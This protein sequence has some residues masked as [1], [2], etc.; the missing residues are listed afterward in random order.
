LRLRWF[1]A[2][3]GLLLFLRWRLCTVDSRDFV[4]DAQEAVHGND[5]PQ[6]RDARERK[7]RQPLQRLRPTLLSLELGIAI[8]CVLRT[9][10]N[11]PLQL[12]LRTFEGQDAR[13]SA[14]RRRAL[15]LGQAFFGVLS[16]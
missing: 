3:R 1:I 2:R 10:L 9:L 16:H 5:G 11:G 15:G 8:Q 14:P 6:Y 4:E 7:D 12:R 13:A